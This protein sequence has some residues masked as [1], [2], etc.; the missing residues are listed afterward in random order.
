MSTQQQAQK[1]VGRIQWEVVTAD[2]QMVAN[3]GYIPNSG[4]VINFTLPASMSA[5]DVVVVSGFGAGGWKILQNSGQVIHNNGTDTTVGAGSGIKSTAQFN[6]AHLLCV[7]D[8]TDLTVDYYVGT[9]A[10]FHPSIFT[11]PTFKANILNGLPA[12]RFN[13]DHDSLIASYLSLM[14][15]TADLR[16]FVV[17]KIEAGN[18]ANTGYSSFVAK[19]KGVAAA[20]INWSLGVWYFGSGLGLALNTDETG[21]SNNGN[22][23]NGYTEYHLATGTYHSADNTLEVH[24][25]GVN[26]T[27]LDQNPGP[28]T[29]LILADNG[30]LQVGGYYNDEAD[31]GFL[32]GDIL[33]IL[34]FTTDLSPSDVA[35]V[36]GNLLQKYALGVGDPMVD[37]DVL[38]LAPKVWVRASDLTLSDGDPVTTWADISGNDIVFTNES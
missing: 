36:E 17:G 25:D 21:F 13:G 16:I 3:H 23:Q 28:P 31:C 4:A 34:I 27:S 9:I 24:K 18:S 38:E 22:Q 14:N 19:L 10:N 6:T 33:E 1:F 26:Q 7:A 12:V 5:G 29:G 30:R 15:A 11:P 35:L 20:P 2:T 32:N 37:S 8:N